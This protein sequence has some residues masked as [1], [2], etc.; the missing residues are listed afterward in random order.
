MA[1]PML[2][3]AAELRRFIRDL[4]VAKGMPTVDATT[5]ADVLVWANL[6]GVDTHGVSRA[7]SYLG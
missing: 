5:I 6:R 2:I 7:S 1:Q 4:F 3:D